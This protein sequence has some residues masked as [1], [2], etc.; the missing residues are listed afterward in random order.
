MVKLIFKESILF[1]QHAKQILRIHW[2]NTRIKHSPS[3]LHVLG[4]W[5]TGKTPV[6]RLFPHACLL[7]SILLTNPLQTFSVKG[8]IVGILSHTGIITTQLYH[9]STKAAID[10][11][12]MVMFVFQ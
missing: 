10:N 12:E 2:T 1:A 5:V 6:V 11:K 3:I 7:H 4:H 9:Y 8:Q